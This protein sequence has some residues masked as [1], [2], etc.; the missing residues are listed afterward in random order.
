MAITLNVQ[1]ENL[2]DV[3][4][5]AYQSDPILKQVISQRQS[6]GEGSVQA[7][8]AFLPLI[9][10]D[11][12][13]RATNQDTPIGQTT[14]VS[15]NSHGYSLD[16]N[17][18]IFDNRNYVNYKISNININR[19]EA[20]LSAAQQSLIIRVAEAYF[21]TL[22]AID[23]VTFSE[24]EKKAIGRQLDQAKRRYEVGIIA[25]T[26]VHEAQAGYDN[27]N[28]QVIAAENSLLVT[29]E[30]LRELT[31]QYIEDV[32]SLADKIPLDPPSPA[33]IQ[34]WVDQATSG[35]FTLL[36]AKEDTYVQKENINLQRSGHYP[37][38]GLKAS[39]GYSKANGPSSFF[40]PQYHESSIGL[41]VSIPIYEGNA[42]TSRTRQAQ[43][44]FQQSQDAYNEVLN[45]TEKNARSSYLNVIS[46][47]SRVKAL[48]QAVVSNISA[49]KATEAGFEVGTRTIVDVLNVQRDLY[50]AKQ[51]HSNSR[52]TYILNVLRLKQASGELA[53]VDLETVNSWLNR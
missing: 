28:A 37:T 43:Y 46:E 45:A 12:Y 32:S 27:A 6:I 8:A 16:V 21:S 52:Y 51:E 10:A 44:D 31:G 13:T 35:N 30:V 50:R 15:F 42:V 48:E 19:A 23:T 24:S 29:K 40:A 47:V 14:D 18:S 2:I 41:N 17:Q 26:D 36:A 1:A 34:H 9:T 5:L 53:R 49:L 22:S 38:L 7:F 33:K 11:A 39:Y 4:G 25:I 20:N 3:Y